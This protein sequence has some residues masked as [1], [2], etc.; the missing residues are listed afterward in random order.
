MDEN[1]YI[2]LADRVKDMIVSGGENVYSLEVENAIATFPGVTQV[3]VVGRPHEIWGEAVHA[4]VVCA[5]GTASESDLDAHARKTI[6]GYKVPKSWTIE[7]DPLP[8]SGAGKILKRELRDRLVG[9]AK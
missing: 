8:L 9:P 3:A 7:S 4:F 2:F 5:P 6:A 1:G